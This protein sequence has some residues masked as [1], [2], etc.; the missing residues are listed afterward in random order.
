MSS[1]VQSFEARELKKRPFI[2][3]IADRLTSFFGSISFLA[4][5]LLFFI[6]WIVF[7]KFDPFP[8]PLLTTIVSLEAIF[9]TIVVLISQQRQSHIT[10]IREELDM[11]VNKYSEREITKILNLLKL[12]TEKQ[13]IKLNDKEL[14]E[15]LN[16]LKLSYI[17]KKLKEQL[18]SSQE[19]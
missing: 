11:Q 16:E 19:N 7:N 6:F 13:G 5:N 3:K 1:V 9:L 2:I 12:I 4:L 17:E 18:T 8:F 15:M 14:D 10:T